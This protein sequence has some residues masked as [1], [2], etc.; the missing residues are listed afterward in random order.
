MKK[1]LML[2][3]SLSII[4]SSTIFCAK[5]KRIPG[6]AKDVLI[7]S[8]AGNPIMGQEEA[9]LREIKEIA[10]T[11]LKNPKS[12]AN[13]KRANRIIN[14][15]MAMGQEEANLREIKNLALAISKNPKSHENSRRAKKIMNRASDLL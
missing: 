11:I 8:D 13:S 7:R 4:S 1:V 3:I 15:A 14:L 2:I 10:R 5:D 9:N 6:A 12:R